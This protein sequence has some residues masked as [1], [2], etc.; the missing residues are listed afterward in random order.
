M[1]TIIVEIEMAMANANARERRL[2]VAPAAA[3]SCPTPRRCRRREPGGET[4]D[5]EKNSTTNNV[6]Q[7]KRLVDNEIDESE[8]CVQLL[9]S[10]AI[11]RCKVGLRNE[12]ER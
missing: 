5:P 12:T 6:I 4:R 3:G 2:A 8:Q 11:D 7:F 1:N 9:S 10:N